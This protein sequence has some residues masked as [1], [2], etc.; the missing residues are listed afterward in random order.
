MIRRHF[1]GFLFVMLFVAPAW[2]VMFAQ[3]QGGTISTFSTGNATETVT[4]NTTG[5]P[6][7]IGFELDRNTTVTSASFF[8][9]PTISGPSPGALELDVNQDGFPEWAFND[10]GYGDFG[11]Q[12]VFSSGNMSE[13]MSIDPNQGTVS[14]PDSPPFYIPTGAAISSMALDVGFSPNLSGGYFQTGYIHAVDKGDLNNDS[15]TEFALLSRTVNVSVT[16]PTGPSVSQVSAFRI[17]AYSNTTGISVSPWQTTC[18]NATRIMMADLN[19]DDHDDVI[20]YAPA[21]DQLCIH[22]TNTSSGGFEPQINVTHASSII[23]LAFGDFTG[24]GLDEMVS[25]QSGGKV[26]VD[27]FSNR[28]NAF[29]NRDS[30]TVFASGSSNSVTLTHMLFAH[31]AGPQNNPYVMATQFSGTANPVYWDTSNNAIVVSTGTVSGVNQG[32]IVGDFDGDQDLDILAPR[33]T[34]HRSIENNGLLG[35]DGDDHNTILT[36]TNAS[37]LDYDLDAD[38]HLLVPNQGNPDGNPATQTGNVSAYAFSSGWGYDNRVS[39]QTTAVFDPWTSPR[40]VHF[41]D[42]D[43]DGSIEQLMLVGEGNQH[44]VFISAYHRV[45]Y[46]IDRDGMVDVGAEGY[47][48]NGSNG[49]SMLMIEDTTSELTN[50]LNVLSPGLPY[51]SDGY[52]IQMAGV[53]LSMHSITEG[54]FTLSGLEVHY[55]ADFLVNANPSVSAN[56]SNVLNQQMTAGSGKLLIPFNFNSTIN[57]T[58]VIYNPNLG[59]IDGAPNIA[60]PPTPDLRFVDVESDRVVIQWQPITA[61]GDDLLDFIVYRSPAGQSVDLQNPLTSTV[62]NNTIDVN[63][64][65][66]QSWTYWVQSIHQFGVTSNL[67]SP[68]TTTVPYPL[69]KSFIPNLTAVD[70]PGDEGGALNISWSLGDE[71]IVEHRLFVLPNNF[72]DV[73]SQTTT[74]T[75]NA[76]TTS[77]VIHEDST[78]HPL[79]DGSAYY[80][81]AI[82]LDVYGNASTNVT[83]VGPVYSR[84]D[85]SLSTTLDVSFTDFTGGELDGTVLLARTKGLEVAAHLHQ[86]GS[87]IANGALTLTIAGTDE[88]YAIEMTTN[89]TGHA[90]LSIDALSSLGPI[91]AVGPMTLNMAY[92]GN[93]GDATNQP[94]EGASSTASAFGT[95]LVSITPDEPIPVQQDGF[96]ET[97]IAVDAEDSV[98]ALYLANMG[99]MWEAFDPNGVQTSNGSADVRGNELLVSGN[100]VYDGHLMIALSNDPPAFYIPGFT[101][102]FALQSPPVVD[103]GTND[104]EETNDTTELTFPAVTLPATVDCGTATY[105]WLDN[106]TDEA[107]SCTITNPNSF[108]VLAGFSWKVIPATPPPITFETSSLS[109]PALII[110]AQGS[111]EVDFQPVRNGPSDG[112]FPGLQGVGY[113]VSITCSEQGGANQ[114]DSMVTPAASTE[115]ELQWTLGEM[116]VQTVDDTP[117]EDD[118]SNAMTPVLVGIGLVLAIGAAI[119]GVLYMRGRDDLDFVDDDDDDEDYFEQALSAP[120][121]TGRPT[122]VDLTAS[123][124]LDELKGSGKSLHTDAPEGLA[125]SPSVGSQADAFEFGATAEDAAGEAADESETWDAEAAEEEAWEEEAVAEDDGITVDENGTEWWEDEEG[126]WW[127]REE[128]WEDWAAW[129]D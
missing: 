17:A 15:N 27:Q 94:L 95:V 54:T 74:L 103:D 55:T 53:N 36:L 92:A 108:D 61:F 104:T 59:F 106:G 26:S 69:P 52:G 49:L 13:T 72:S 22:F 75:T 90:T 56:L 124:S 129:E 87:G 112:L 102:S 125:T 118:A 31:F 7:S 66:G 96:F 71:S 123:K 39:S 80:V 60:L 48:G 83:A 77:L 88:T 4:V 111:T 70:V 82:G 46:D 101:N 6:S 5:Q 30:V 98:Q 34:G 28:T 116:P 44:G 58:F 11:H 67:S 122:S 85:S 81:A 19:G 42:M 93:Q 16:T 62:A 14:N 33:P 109:G 110:S 121:Q 86:N 105:A 115:G 126:I 89:I 47:A 8:I 76:T 50:T 40:A 117:I 10:T 43:G 99:V 97:I 24:N 128:G 68:L 1:L 65:P 32:S 12:T 57:G 100:A 73:A 18:T 21:A 9:K 84:N 63:V 45:G 107:I 3:A 35:W 79:V 41:G 119:G 113:V 29:T 78:G 114:C 20:G 51:T 38:A 120:E 64:Q 127:Y 2:S 91:D 23:D 37:I 25:I